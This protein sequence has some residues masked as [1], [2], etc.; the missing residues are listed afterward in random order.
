MKD[1]RFTAR[2]FK[3]QA[4]VPGYA[5]RCADA[6]TCELLIRLTERLAE[7]EDEKEKEEER[8]SNE[9]SCE[10]QRGDGGDPH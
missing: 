1:K 2:D 8:K 9:Y 7:I 4:Y 3:G 5:P 10:C 6:Q